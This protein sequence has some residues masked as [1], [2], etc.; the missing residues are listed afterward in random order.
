MEKVPV[1]VLILA[2]NEEKNIADCIKSVPFAAEIIVI[3]DFSSDKTADISRSLGAKVI[4]HALEGNW[5]AQQTF[6]I[7]QASLP[8]IFFLDA[9]ERVSAAL[10]EE[11][12]RLVGIDDRNLAYA[13]ARLSYFWGQPLRHGGW[14][15][16]YVTRLIPTAQTYVTGF[17]HPK[18]VH[19][20][21]EIKLPSKMYLIHYPY[22]D[23]EH[24]FGKLNFY[25]TLAAKKARE[26]G[27]TATL[28][29]MLMH[30][31]WAAFRMYL[32]RGGWRDGRIGF[33]LS[34]FHFFY[35]MAK[36]VKLYY[37]TKTNDHVGDK[38]SC[39]NL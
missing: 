5:G 3:D 36:Y 28:L 23:W 22:R 7:K 15:P 39:K 31:A 30:P 18:I 14:Y 21:R 37:L 25:T 4:D 27:R 17:V 26:Q 19:P 24:Y 35:T 11:I 6:A 34:M 13:C 8:W 12:V 32:L 38:D 33:I 16:D 20:Y 2:K 10:G 29:D 9:D 1:S